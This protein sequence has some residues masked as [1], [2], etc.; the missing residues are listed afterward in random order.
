MKSLPATPTAVAHPCD[1]ASLSGAI[2]AARM[3]IIV[4]ILVGPRHKILAAAKAANLDVTPYEIVD[5]EHSHD[6]AEKAVSL[7]REGR[8]EMLMKGSL[9]TDELLGAVRIAVIVAV[10]T[11]VPASQLLI[12]IAFA[13]HA[14]TMLTLLGS[15]PNVLVNNAAQGANLRPFGFFE[16]AWLGVPM[17]N[18]LTGLRPSV[19]FPSP[20]RTRWPEV[21]SR[22]ALAG[23]A[24]L[25]P[26]GSTRSASPARF[27]P[28]AAPCGERGLSPLGA[29]GS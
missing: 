22:P 2:D 21:P 20:W 6:A 13:G 15:N 16:Y 7:V 9:S 27:A 14:A 10:R 4:P 26:P 24:D 1:E 18:L 29:V 17:M 28:H 12:P 19:R 8:A 23:S 11:G 5:A 25:R 3:N